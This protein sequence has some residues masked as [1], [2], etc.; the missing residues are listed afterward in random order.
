MSRKF[1]IVLAIIYT[2]NI[3]MNI[4]TRDWVA[5][6]GWTCAFLSQLRIISLIEED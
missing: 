5:C 4:F 1:E 3:A 2:L 6:M